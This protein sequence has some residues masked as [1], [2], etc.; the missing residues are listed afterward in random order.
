MLRKS[1]DVQPLPAASRERIRSAVFA[2]LDR[3]VAPA[4]DDSSGTARLSTDG[5][6]NLQPRRWPIAAIT[7]VVAAAALLLVFLDTRHQAPNPPGGPVD[8]HSR[9]VTEAASS[10]LS[11]DDAELTV[12]AASAVVIERSS[13]R[14]VLVVLERGGVR[15]AVLPRPDRAPFRVQAGDVRIEVMGTEF[16]VYRHGD[17][18][19]VDVERGTVAVLYG[20]ERLLVE[21]GETWASEEDMTQ[22]AAADGVDQEGDGADEFDDRARAPRGDRHHRTRKPHRRRRHRPRATRQAAPAVAED[23]ASPTQALDEAISDPTTENAPGDSEAA[24][25]PPA[26]EPVA[27]EPVAAPA[28]P[29]LTAKQRYER[30]ERLEATAAAEALEIYRELVRE[31]GP[32]APTALFAQARLEYE[33]GNLS[34]AR[35]LLQ[36]YLRRYPRGANASMARRLLERID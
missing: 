5:V 22:T 34:R 15:C 35:S 11:L 20:G 29:A 16:A 8:G 24:D 31:G 1:L 18:A 4:P 7:A 30:A 23:Q 9:V 12:A 19:R 21:A 14:G 3:E 2:R 26:D 33:R 17:A 32:W 13:D 25:E 10:T 6:P 28:P 27:D 36:S